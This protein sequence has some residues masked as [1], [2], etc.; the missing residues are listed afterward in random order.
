MRQLCEHLVSALGWYGIEAALPEPEPSNYD[1]WEVSF[2]LATNR[3]TNPDG[4]RRLQL[5]GYFTRNGKWLF[6]YAS[7]AYSLKPND[8]SALSAVKN[9]VATPNGNPAWMSEFE[10]DEQRHAV[11]LSVRTCVAGVNCLRTLV[12]HLLDDVLNSV[13]YYHDLMQIAV[14]QG[15]CVPAVVHDAAF[16]AS[17]FATANAAEEDD[18]AEDAAEDEDEDEDELE[19]VEEESASSQP[20]PPPRR[21]QLPWE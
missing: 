19:G 7:E 18:A 8:H 14:Q 10:V 3:Y 21:R 6:L 20:P 11:S 13:D 15:Q 16:L 17:L 1:G 2:E 5:V 9:A 12:Q 4:K